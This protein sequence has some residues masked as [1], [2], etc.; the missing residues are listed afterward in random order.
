[1]ANRPGEVRPG[2][3]GKPIRG[4]DVRLVDDEGKDVQAGHGRQPDGSGRVDSSF[5]RASV[6]KKP[7]THL[8]VKW[9]FTGDQYL[10]DKDGYYWH[11]GRVDDMLKV[12]GLWVSPMEI[13]EGAERA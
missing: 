5:L 4:Y 13:E 7:G 2:S 10:Q 1:M 3:S 12:G 6:R 8:E 9:L 11:K